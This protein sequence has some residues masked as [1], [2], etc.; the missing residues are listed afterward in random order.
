[1]PFKTQLRHIWQF[2][3]HENLHRLFLLIIIFVV[4]SSIGITWVEPDMTLFNG[5]WWSIVTM[6]TVGYGD[7]SPITVSG[8]LIAIVLMFFGIGLLGTFSAT[9]ASVMVERKLKED[10]GMNSYNFENHIILCEWNYRARVILSEFRT[11]PQTAEAPIVLIAD[12]ERKPVNDPHL[13]FIQGNVNDETLRRA[14][15]AR[16]KTVVIVGDNRMEATARDAKVVL[17]TLTVESINPDAYTVVELI[18]DA[19]VQHCERANADEIIVT[20][21]IS[22]SLMARAAIEHGTTRVISEILQSGQG[23][24]LYKLPVPDSMIGRQL[25]DL[26]LKIK[27]EYHTTI[28]AIQKGNQG[29][30]ITNPPLDYRLE[31]GDYFIMIAT[32]R[33]ELF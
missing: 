31:P 4:A 13:F 29:M 19:N 22:S 33:P 8:R 15:L 11:D 25:S 28:I 5:I 16:A 14:N 20:N 32:E 17:T 12:I 26:F 18:D 9:I 21:E 27:Q 24:E 6:T 23:N 2:L 30:T 1:M 10:L 7:I 3:Q